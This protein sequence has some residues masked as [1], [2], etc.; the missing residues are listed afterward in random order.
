MMLWKWIKDKMLFKKAAQH[1][2]DDDLQQQAKWAYEHRFDVSDFIECTIIVAL[3][4]IAVSVAWW[5]IM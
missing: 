3:I 5:L 1:I 4:I 2:D